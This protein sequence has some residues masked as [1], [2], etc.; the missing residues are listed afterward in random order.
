MGTLVTGVETAYAKRR[1]T[2]TRWT[3]VKTARRSREHIQSTAPEPA[4]L[5]GRRMLETESNPTIHDAGTK[6]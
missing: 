4:H 6:M 2:L 1:R 3:A 5:D